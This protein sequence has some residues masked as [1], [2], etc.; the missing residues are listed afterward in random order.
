MVSSTCRVRKSS[1]RKWPS[2]VANS[3]FVCVV[4]M[5][6]ISGCSPKYYAP[7]TH[8][9]PLL[10]QKG[11]GVTSFV[12]GE[13]RAELQGAYAVSGSVA[14]MLNAASLNPKDDEEGDG[15][16]GGLLEIG[17]GYY[18]TLSK[19]VVFETYGLLGRGDVENHFP[20]VGKHLMRRVTCLRVDTA[21]IGRA[22]ARRAV[23][24][25]RVGS[26]TRFGCLHHV[27]APVVGSLEVGAEG[28]DEKNSHGNVEPE[29]TA[30][31]A[32]TRRHDQKT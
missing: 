5:F 4:L 12:I 30:S 6:L 1:S 18:H 25:A 23:S 28:T 24:S 19:N 7:N 17:V 21:T 8:N 31:C 3:T 29:S 27:L 32:V 9:V 14:L 26:A 22:T 2:Y 13:G 11:E 15:G 20:V 10:D 16:K